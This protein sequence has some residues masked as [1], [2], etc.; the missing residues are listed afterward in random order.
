MS[1]RRVSQ[2]PVDNTPDFLVKRKDQ[3]EAELGDRILIGERIIEKQIN[4]RDDLAK[5]SQEYT[6]WNDYNAEF[7]KRAFNRS[8]NQFF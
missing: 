1:K 2:S 8:D 5:A 4:N 6:S 7:I 3:F